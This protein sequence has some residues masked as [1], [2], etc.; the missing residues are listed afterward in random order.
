MQIYISRA[1]RPYTFRLLSQRFSTR[2]VC[3]VTILIVFGLVAL[4]FTLGSVSAQSDDHQ[5]DA[6]QLTR[7]L[8][9]LNKHLQQSDPT[10]RSRLLDDLFALVTERQQLLAAIVEDNPGEVLRLAVPLNVR[11]R[12]PVAV[13]GYLEEEVEVEGKLEA[14]VEEGEGWER[15]NYYLKN[16]KGRYA[17]HFAGDSSEL[18]PGAHLR[19]RGVRLPSDFTSSDDASIV[20]AYCCDSSSVETLATPT[21]VLEHTLGEQ[22]TLV[23]LV[24]FLDTSDLQPFTLQEA[25]EAV[26]GTVHDFYYEASYGQTWLAGDVRGWYTLPI[27]STCNSIDITPAA[28]AAAIAD[29]I[30]LSAYARFIYVFKGSASCFWSGAST[31]WQ[32]PSRA[33]MNGNISPL[34]IAHELGHSFGLNHSNLLDC[35]NTVLGPDCVT[36]QDDKFDAIGAAPEPGHFNAFQKERLGWFRPGD[37]LFIATDGTYTIYPYELD[38]GAQPKVIKFLKEIDSG[39]QG[40]AWYYLELRQALGFDSFIE[41]NVNV[42]NGLLVHTGADFDGNSS[43]LLDMTPNSSTL[44]FKD[45]SDPA[46]AVGQSFTDLLSGLTITTE[47]VSTTAATV[48]VKFGQPSCVHRAPTV[49]ISPPEGP[50]VAAGTSVSYDITVTNTDSY[51]CAETGFTLS[52][53]AP[54]GWLALFD[55]E[56]LTLAPGTSGTATLTVTSDTA[57]A[58]GFYDIVAFAEHQASPTYAGSATAAYVINFETDN[59]PPNP[60]D[61][62]SATTVDTAVVIDVLANDTDPDGDSLFITGVGRGDNGTASAN[63]DGTVTYLPKRRFKGTDTFTYTVGDGIDAA[64]ATVLVTVDGKNGNGKKGKGR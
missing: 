25:Q 29:G 63:A 26:F 22:R 30:D 18:N 64:S 39:G 32:Y 4:S 31:L 14:I 23:L 19:I 10:V 17:L 43:L 2:L 20:I 35:G 53:A 45:R 24:N 61:D 6:E 62:E 33:W 54:D 1:R 42:L 7:S 57:A 5:A 55:T 44:S 51:V 37:V 11:N 13:Q 56:V 49:S 34:I 27:N 47:Q 40:A 12:L 16:S 21:P 9:A 38:N 46:L 15:L 48:T 36:A 50:W 59:Q 52:S 58:D 28:D 3:A 41:D 8:I 60:V